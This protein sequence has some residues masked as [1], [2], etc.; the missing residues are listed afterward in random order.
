MA[1]SGATAHPPVRRALIIESLQVVRMVRFD[2]RAK[3]MS[4]IIFSGTIFSGLSIEEAL[5][6][7]VIP[8]P[9]PGSIPL[10]DRWI[11]DQVRD[12]VCS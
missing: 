5:I 7:S 11:P 8:A 12:D 3:M 4:I 2:H 9:E 1:G 10:Y 6:Y